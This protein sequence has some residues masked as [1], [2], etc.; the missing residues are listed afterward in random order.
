MDEKTSF[1]AK[2]EAAVHGDRESS[3]PRD[4]G[5]VLLSCNDEPFHCWVRRFGTF[6]WRLHPRGTAREPGWSG[7]F[8]GDA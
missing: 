4:T 6:R 2:K 5:L 7:L 3:R 1:A 8:M